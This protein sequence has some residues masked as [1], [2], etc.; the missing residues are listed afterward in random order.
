MLTMVGLLVFLVGWIWLIVIGF[1]K[2]GALWGI[3]IFFF[4]W[5]AG[6]IF[7][8]MKKEGW[9]QFGL[10]ILGFILIIAGGGGSFSIGNMPN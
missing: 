2:G 6:L 3:L 5:L 4:N 10:M 7:A 8:I 9:L 1:Q